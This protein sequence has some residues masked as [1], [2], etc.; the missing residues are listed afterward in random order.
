MV[1]FSDM[2]TSDHDWL[3]NIMPLL[4]KYVFFKTGECVIARESFWSFHVMLEL[5]WPGRNFQPITVSIFYQEQHHSNI[6]WN[7]QE[8]LFGESE[9]AS[10]EKKVSTA[11][12]QCAP[13]QVMIVLS[14]G[15]GKTLARQ[16]YHYHLLK[17]TCT[18][19]ARA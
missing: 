6:T 4:I 15:D 12:T 11:N 1:C 7:E 8:N 14:R 9:F 18:T 10:L 2:I 5:F 3:V 16:S 13:N 17:F 19:L